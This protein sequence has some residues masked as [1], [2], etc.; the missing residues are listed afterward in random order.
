MLV[1]SICA[2]I[3][4]TIWQF[5]NYTDSLYPKEYLE[6]C[7][8]DDKDGHSDHWTISVCRA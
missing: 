3:I 8:I 4:G 1:R 2:G 7:P 6:W 5:E